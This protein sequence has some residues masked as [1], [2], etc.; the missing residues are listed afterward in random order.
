MQ[1]C[2]R[3][4]RERCKD[5]CSIRKVKAPFHHAKLRKLPPKNECTALIDAIQRDSED[6]LCTYDCGESITKQL[7]CTFFFPQC[8]IAPPLFLWNKYIYLNRSTQIPKSIY[9][10]PKA[11]CHLLSLCQEAAGLDS[12]SCSTVFVFGSVSYLYPQ[13]Q[14]LFQFV[15]F[16]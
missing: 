1:T 13:N 9:F 11:A 7:Q 15:N 10:M 4:I 8:I 5:L 14:E 16:S 3:I 6:N 2:F 12:C